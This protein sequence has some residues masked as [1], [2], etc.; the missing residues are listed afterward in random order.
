M[1]LAVGVALAL[2]G[3]TGSGTAGTSDGAVTGPTANDGAP[4]TPGDPPPRTLQ[5]IV[6]E[7]MK[8]Q[9]F[10]YIPVDT[11]QAAALAVSDVRAP[12]APRPGTREF[13]MELG[14]GIS[15]WDIGDGEPADVELGQEAPDQEN[16]DSLSENGRE[17]AEEELAS[18]DWVQDPAT[19]RQEREATEG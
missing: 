7:C 16:V 14:Y 15:T 1:A 13:A 8:E 2:G 5:Q 17:A 11:S 6:A 12:D 9:G 10:E 3:R 4:A 18:D 19:I